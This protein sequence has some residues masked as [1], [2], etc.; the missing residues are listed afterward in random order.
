MWCGH[1]ARNRF[2]YG[3]LQIRPKTVQFPVEQKVTLNKPDFDIKYISVG[4]YYS[5]FLCFRP[6]YLMPYFFIGAFF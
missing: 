3:N 6:T 1:N 2:R 4:A 5:P